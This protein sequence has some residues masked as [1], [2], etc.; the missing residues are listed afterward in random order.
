MRKSRAVSV[1]RLSRRAPSL[2]ERTRRRQVALA[3]QI[4]ALDVRIGK[5]H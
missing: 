1:A 2:S 5:K 3:A 4:G